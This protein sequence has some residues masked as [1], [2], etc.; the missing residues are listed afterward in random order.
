MSPLVLRSPEA[1]LRSGSVALLALLLAW[2]AA[3]RDVVADVVL[4]VAA[5]ALL[6][7][8]LR[9][10]AN[11][12]IADEHGLTDVRTF[13]RVHLPWTGLT[14]FDVARPGGLWAGFCVRAL[15][16]EDEHDLL[17]LR[18]YSRKWTVTDQGQLYRMA[19]ALEDLR[20]EHGTPDGPRSP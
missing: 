10:R 7:L 6:P 5:V 15:E 4:G 2:G 12:V 3:T 16:A 9:M 8:A 14:G 18:A 17:G 11:R 20:R 19:W 1:S 13:R